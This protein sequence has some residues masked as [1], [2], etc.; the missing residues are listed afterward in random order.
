M[1]CHRG[2]HGQ[3][4]KGPRHPET[5]DECEPC[6]ATHCQVCRSRHLDGDA[7]TCPQCVGVIRADLRAIA[8][9]TVYLPQQ[10]AYG[11][12]HGHLEAAKPIP[13]GDATVLMA[14]GG[15]GTTSSP[16]E[17]PADP[18]PPLLLL[19]Q[20]EDDFRAQHRHPGGPRATMPS[21]TGYLHKH[22]TWAAQHHPAIA[23][24][25]T[26]LARCRAR[27]ENVLRHGDRDDTAAAPCF[28]CAG[29]LVRK[30]TPTGRAD[31]Y[32]CR[33]CRRDYTVAEYWLALRV[34]LEDEAG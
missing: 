12:S 18:I 30:T 33:R 24:F 23:D 19:S 17:S 5:H 3:R 6:S 31:H 32:T 22:L 20:W 10:A 11:G 13:G 25:A 9:L 1:T 26:D 7:Q 2:P 15:T 28:D 27:L 8:A 14:W 34:A 4:Y 16:D 29:R 21:V